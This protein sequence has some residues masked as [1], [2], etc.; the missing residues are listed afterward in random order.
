VEHI[1][2]VSHHE[3]VVAGGCH[4]HGQ[5][6]RWQQARRQ[7]LGMLP[8]RAAAAGG[9]PYGRGARAG[10]SAVWRLGAGDSSRQ[11]FSAVLSFSETFFFEFFGPFRLLNINCD[12]SVIY[13]YKC[14]LSESKFTLTILNCFGNSKKTVS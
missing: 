2:Q 4:A 6:P 13:L 1:A 10:G 5:S 3:V 7:A 8:K 9:A 14:L 12:Y 11:S